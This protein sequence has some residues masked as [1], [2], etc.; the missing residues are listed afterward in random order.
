MFYLE[1]FFLK[2]GFN[3]L[4]DWDCIMGCIVVFLLLVSSGILLCV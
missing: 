3:F 4:V 2:V 1:M